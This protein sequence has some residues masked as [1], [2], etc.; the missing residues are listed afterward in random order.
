MQLRTYAH[1]HKAEEDKSETVKNIAAKKYIDD[2]EEEEETGI[3]LN[4]GDLNLRNSST[5]S[6]EERLGNLDLFYAAL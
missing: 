5:I 4:L 3:Y 1:T 6:M 2:E